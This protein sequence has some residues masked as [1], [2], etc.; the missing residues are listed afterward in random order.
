MEDNCPLFRHRFSDVIGAWL[1]RDLERLLLFS[2]WP[3]FSTRSWKHVQ[4]IYTKKEIVRIFRTWIIFEERRRG[5]VRLITRI[6]RSSKGR[7]KGWSSWLIMVADHNLCISRAGF[8]SSTVFFV[9][10]NIQIVANSISRK[11][12]LINSMWS[13]NTR[14]PL[15]IWFESIS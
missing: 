10:K 15:E 3:R 11:N 6:S 12:K 4:F 13:I 7:Q 5:R 1:T 14:V 8:D 9:I 2:P